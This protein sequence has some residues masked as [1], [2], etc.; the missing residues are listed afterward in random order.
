MLMSWKPGTARTS[1]KKKGRISMYEWIASD[2]AYEVTAHLLENYVRGDC[3]VTLVMRHSCAFLQSFRNETSKVWIPS[4][5]E[6]F[7]SLIE[8]R[9][10]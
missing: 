1:W 6:D 7:A 5:D 2:I 4:V 9:F 10:Q 3:R 8:E